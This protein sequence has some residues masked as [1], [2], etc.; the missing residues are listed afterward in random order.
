MSQDLL[1]RLNKIQAEVIKNNLSLKRLK[2]LRRLT[3]E[4]LDEKI[5][6][7]ILK[8]NL[9]KKIKTPRSYIKLWTYK[10]K[11]IQINV[12]WR[13][14]ISTPFIYCMIF[15]A[16]LWHICIEIYQQVCFRLYQIPLVNYKE[17]F[18]YDRQLLSWLNLLEKMNC[19]YCSYVNNLIRY[20]AEIGGRTERYWCPIKYYRRI[21]NPHSQYNKFIAQKNPEKMR[22]QWEELRNFNDLS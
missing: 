2:E 15:P 12:N 3:K 1:E 22:Q 10:G 19:Y 4:Y 11:P 9:V 16:I 8:N 7:I 21:N 18:I 6:Q 20:S 5:D 14:L 17:Y 13:Y